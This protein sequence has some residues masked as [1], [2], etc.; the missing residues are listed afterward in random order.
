[1]AE[2]VISHTILTINLN[3]YNFSIQVFIKRQHF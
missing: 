1:M 2:M 3:F